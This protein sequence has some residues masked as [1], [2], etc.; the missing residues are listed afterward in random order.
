M[1]YCKIKLVKL[2]TNKM[3]SRSITLKREFYG[4]CECVGTAQ[5][6]QPEWHTKHLHKYL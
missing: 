1:I 4:C 5:P 3:Q 6:W 2:L